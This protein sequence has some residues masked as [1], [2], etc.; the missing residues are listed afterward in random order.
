MC[1]STR[2]THICGNCGITVMSL[3]RTD[4][5][6]LPQRGVLSERDSNRDFDVDEYCAGVEDGGEEELDSSCYNCL[7]EEIEVED[8]DDQL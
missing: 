6:G 3:S 8:V 2:I 4:P 1:V 7:E 5:C